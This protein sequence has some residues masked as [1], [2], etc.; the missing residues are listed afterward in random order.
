MSTCRSALLA[1]AI[2]ALSG[3]V[4]VNQDAPMPA[5]IRA[6]GLQLERGLPKALPGDSKVIAGSQLVL[7]PTESAAGLFVP[8]PFVSD[9]V[10][11][12]YHQHQA[13]ALASHYAAIDLFGIVQHAWEGSALLK[14][15]PGAHSLYPVGYLVACA[16]QQYRLA[17][18]GRIEQGT[19]TG[20]YVVHLPTAYREDALAAAAPETLA[21]IRREFGA[22]ALIMRDLV[23]RDAS[24]ALQESRYRAD[25]GSLH[26]A[27]ARPAGLLAP[28]MLLA[29]GAQVLEDA[30]DHIIV[31]I[32]GDLRQSGPSGGLLYGVH[33]LRKD[34]LHTFQRK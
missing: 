32:G 28:E 1:S 31:R 16:D 23:E 20:R 6:Q 14:E 11:S 25:V 34:Q 27:C 24:G 33:Y 22:A 3:C 2:L 5:E 12:A 18:A 15:G 13:T 29:R 19:W 17:L 4:T 21:S 10:A 8:V 9:V 30:P 26:L 7:V